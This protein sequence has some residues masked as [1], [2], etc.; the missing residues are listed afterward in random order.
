[1]RL[2]LDAVETTRAHAG[3]SRLE[4]LRIMPLSRQR[5]ATNFAA[6]E[7]SSDADDAPD[8]PTPRN[9]DKSSA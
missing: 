9:R 3:G 5:D 8:K 6:G 1:M 2:L 7:L 4:R